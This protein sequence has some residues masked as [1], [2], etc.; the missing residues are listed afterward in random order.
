M[1]LNIDDTKQEQYMN[2]MVRDTDVLVNCEE[3]NRL[4]YI[5]YNVGRKKIEAIPPVKILCNRCINK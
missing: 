1:K 2:S 5:N 4:F 3:C